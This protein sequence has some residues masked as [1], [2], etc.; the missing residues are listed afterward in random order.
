MFNRRIRLVL[1]GLV[2][3]TMLF[4][5][6]VGA[7]Q[8]C[9]GS[10]DTPAMAF[11]DMQCDEMPTQNVCLQQYLEGDQNSGI[12]DVPVADLSQVVVLVADALPVE[13]PRLLPDER[14][15]LRGTSDPPPNILFCSF[16][17]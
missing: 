3:V 4:A 1:N 8:A 5:Q 16:Q 14:P 9:S 10:R 17:L 2:L 11:S 7:A 6:W 13:Q 12:P 15:C